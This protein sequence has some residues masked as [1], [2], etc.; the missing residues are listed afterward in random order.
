[1]PFTADFRK[2]IESNIPDVIT[3]ALEDKE[4]NVRA[5]GV[6]ALMNLAEESAS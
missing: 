6:R 4:N 3:L 1:M 5:A 2:L